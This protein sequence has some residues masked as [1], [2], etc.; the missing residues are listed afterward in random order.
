MR[1][2][3]PVASLLFAAFVF[4]ADGGL[5]ATARA[6]QTVEAS[7][8]SAPADK[9]EL[10]KLFDAVIDTVD[11]RFVDVE[12]LK[13]LPWRTRAAEIRDSVLNAATTAEAVERINGL[14]R[15]LNTS[16][17]ALYTPD[18]YEYY[19]LLDIVGGGSATEVIA[20]KFW[21]A[22][23]YY[24][25]VGI[26]T[27]KVGERN[28]VDSVMEG[29]PAD[30]AGLKVGDEIISVDGQPYTPVAAFRGKIGRG[31][32]LE[33]RRERDGPT[34]TMQV[35]VIPIKPSTAFAAA[36]RAGARVIERNG[37][38]IGYVRLWS[39]SDARNF[40]NA[41]AA[42]DPSRA[43]QPRGRRGG[44]SGNSPQ[45]DSLIIDM[46]GRV[47]GYVGAASE[48]LDILD[49]GQKPYWGRLDISGREGDR[50]NRPDAATPRAQTFR[51]RSI[52]LTD[53]HTRSA[54]ELVAFGYK[55]GGF[56]PIMGTPT[57]GAVTSGAVEMMPG[58]LLLYVAVSTLEFDGRRI[59]GAGVAPDQAIERPLAY[60][61]GADPVL[62]AAVEKLGGALTR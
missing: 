10:G 38:R 3:L 27:A 5:P 33:I 7:A 1:Q 8:S 62:D 29:S 60:A 35:D 36:T 54:G 18:D 45:L 53:H 57:A 9:A 24:P 16:H 56:G 12:T 23:P 15:E 51:G 22:G 34:Q 28:F 4:C 50:P 25:G 43:E 41:L 44:G 11:R 14:L 55:Q 49:R 52:M 19:I 59:E 31:V 20:R 46:R 39:V 21:G 40:Q 26:F 2:P 47:G 37:R 58:D 32:A 17:T 61:N 6:E 13:R 30:K 42:I 48:M